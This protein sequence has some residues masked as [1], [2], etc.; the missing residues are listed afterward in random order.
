MNALDAAISSNTHFGEAARSM[1]HLLQ[2][3]APGCMVLGAPE[4][5]RW[6][7]F[8]IEEQREIKRLHEQEGWS[9]GKLAKK[10]SRSGTQI[11]KAIRLE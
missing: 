8:P 7:R 5:R 3:H 1:I 9:Y 6:V 10:F 11:T 4:R 2:K